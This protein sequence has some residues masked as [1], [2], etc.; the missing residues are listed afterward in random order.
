MIHKVLLQ[1]YK[2][3][4]FTSIT[5]CQEMSIH[6]L[7]EREQPLNTSVQEIQSLIRH[8]SLG[9]IEFQFY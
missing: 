8:L 4:S 6:V 7:I 5:S 9:G 3:L 2:A 1:C